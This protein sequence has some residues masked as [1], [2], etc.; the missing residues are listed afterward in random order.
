MQRHEMLNR[1]EAS[2]NPVDPRLGYWVICPGV[3]Q[4]VLPQYRQDVLHVEDDLVFFLPAG[5][6]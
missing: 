2:S 4:I 1:L 3:D 6:G 5:S